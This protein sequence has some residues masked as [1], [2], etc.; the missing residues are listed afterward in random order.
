MGMQGLLRSADVFFVPTYEIHWYEGLG[1]IARARAAT[2]ARDAAPL[3]RAAEHSFGEY[4]KGAEGKND[5]WM[6][7]AKARLAQAKAERE[8][9]EKAAP[10]EPVPEPV[11][12]AVR[13]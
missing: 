1:A 3:W 11:P 4:V 13:L 2:S 5:R 7:I 12:D 10:R 8:R 6:A 9:A